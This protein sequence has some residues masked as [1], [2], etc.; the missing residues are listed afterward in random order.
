MSSKD[1]VYVL[2]PVF[3]VA[4]FTFIY[5][6]KNKIYTARF[7]RLS[8]ALHG[9]F[10]KFS[11]IPTFKG[12]YQGLKFSIEVVG[13]TRGRPPYLKLFLNKKSS[14][15]LHIYKKAFLR[16]TVINLGLLREFKTG[17]EAFEKEFLLSTNNANSAATYL[18]NPNTKATIKELFN[19]GFTLLVV[20]GETIFARKPDYDLNLDLEPNNITAYLKSLSSLAQGL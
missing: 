11:L 9:S 5:F 7:K 10:Y 6:L 19:R 8:N 17:D 2:F 20:N 1:W 13:P 4:F 14:F 18:N 3:F 16:E 15:K 12:E